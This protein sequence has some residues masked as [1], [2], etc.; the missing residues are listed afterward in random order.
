MSSIVNVLVANLTNGV[1]P[2][3]EISIKAE[4]R[5]K[6]LLLENRTKTELKKVYQINYR[7]ES[8]SAKKDS[9]IGEGKLPP[10]PPPEKYGD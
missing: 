10:P 1:T 7:V 6:H 3:N 8:N 2:Q 4:I 9:L 5:P